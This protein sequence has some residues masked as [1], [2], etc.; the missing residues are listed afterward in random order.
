MEVKH[1]PTKWCTPGVY[2]LKFMD[3]YNRVLGVYVGSSSNLARR[4]R[5][6]ARDVFHSKALEHAASKAKHIQI[7]VIELLPQGMTK[8]G[9]ALQEQTTL[10]SYAYTPGLLNQNSRAVV[11]AHGTVLT[12][13]F[14]DGDSAEAST[15]D[16][17]RAHGKMLSYVSAGHAH[18]ARS[19]STGK[20]VGLD[21]TRLDMPG[22]FT[23]AYKAVMREK[24]RCLEVKP[25]YRLTPEAKESRRAYARNYRPEY[26][27]RDYVIR[28]NREYAKA[29]RSRPD[30]KAYRT[31]YMKEYDQQRSFS[32]GWKAYRSSINRS[33][34]LRKALQRLGEDMRY[35]VRMAGH[36]IPNAHPALPEVAAWVLMSQIRQ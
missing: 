10:D 17:I 7:E 3:H 6:Y 12:W 24:Y 14:E 30:V 8:T 21:R 29:Y 25:K 33:Y 32:P 2:V 13:V 34:R 19:K 27:K 16:M 18:W 9:I 15:A 28:K 11:N 35:T 36:K 5:D 26:N 23:D 31:E 20:R 1:P 22:Q 4:W